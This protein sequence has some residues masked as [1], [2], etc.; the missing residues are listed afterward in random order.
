MAISIR[1]RPIY[2][3]TDGILSTMTMAEN[4]G[5][6]LAFEGN[7][8]K[9]IHRKHTYVANFTIVANRKI[10]S[11]IFTLRQ[12]MYAKYASLKISLRAN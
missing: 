7:A 8:D 3:F 9:K 5:K 2:R 4:V 1:F 6:N 10:V 12:E 11:L